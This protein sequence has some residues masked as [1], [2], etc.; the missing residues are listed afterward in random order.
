VT[1]VGFFHGVV[2]HELSTFRLVKT[3]ANSVAGVLIERHVGCVNRLAFRHD[4]H[5]TCFQLEMHGTVR[6]CTRAFAAP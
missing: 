1:L 5:D 2:R 6:L 3:L 4:F